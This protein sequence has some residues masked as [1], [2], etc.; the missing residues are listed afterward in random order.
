VID[1]LLRRADALDAF[2]E[3]DRV[4]GERLIAYGEELVVKGKGTG[5]Q[6]LVDAGERI[7][8]LGGKR[9]GNSVVLRAE[10]EAFRIVAHILQIDF[11][12]N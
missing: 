4:A 7:K 10:A 11:I 5:G 9:L 2:A 3:Q 1:A 8:A 6:S 12:P